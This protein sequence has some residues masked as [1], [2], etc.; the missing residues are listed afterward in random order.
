MK[1][2]YQILALAAIAVTALV[3]CQKEAA[4]NDDTNKPAETVNSMVLPSGKQIIDKALLCKSDYTDL[5]YAEVQLYGKDGSFL[6]V[7]IPHGFWG[8]TAGIEARDPVTSMYSY[9]TI[10]SGTVYYPASSEVGPGN[11]LVFSIDETKMTIKLEVD[12]K[13]KDA[14]QFSVKYSGPV[15]FSDK[16]Y[17]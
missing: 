3:S 14:E 15:G 5:N 12:L 2:F 9:V 16:C 10:D 1:S 11:S 6:V 7:G 13:T 17:D 8:K 4:K